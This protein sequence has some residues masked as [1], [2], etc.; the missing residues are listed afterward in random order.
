MSHRTPLKPWL[1]GQS[2]FC[3]YKRMYI[4]PT[5]YVLHIA[6]ITLNIQ[7]KLS[8]FFG[9]ERKIKSNTGKGDKNDLQIS[10][11]YLNSWKHTI[12]F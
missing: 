5:Y 11:L 9:Q 8:F 12:R 4:C 7:S 1:P 3:L 2:I 6:G 10:L